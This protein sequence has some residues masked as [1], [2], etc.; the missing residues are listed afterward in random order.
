MMQ[1][2]QIDDIAEKLA[3]LS[4][5]GA[6][7]V[8][9]FDG[10]IDTIVRVVSGGPD[11]A[12][13]HFATKRAFGEKLVALGRANASFELTEVATKI[14]GNAPNTAQACGRLGLQ[15]EC[16][17]MLGHPEIHDLFAGMHA[18]CRL[19][20]FAPPTQTTALEFDDGKVLL[21]GSRIL[22]T[23]DW[24]AV[25][26]G[27]GLERLRALYADAD[28]VG[29]T[30]WGEIEHATAIWEGAEAGV[31]AAIAPRRRIVFFDLA[32][33]RRR[34]A[35][36]ARLFALIE[37]LTAGNETVLS[38]NRNEAQAVAR[39]LAVVTDGS[40][41]QLGAAIHRAI[42]VD[43]LIL[44]DPFEALA[45][46]AAGQDRTPTFHLAAPRVSTGGGDNF[47]AGYCFAR[48]AGLDTR[49][50]LLVAS[51]VAR[52]YVGNGESPDCAQLVDFLRAQAAG[53]T[54][55]REVAQ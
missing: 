49:A 23:V 36:F 39:H 2:D 10:F 55:A 11:E 34:Q 41:E 46:T 16:I 7:A 3:A 21:A 25:R 5:G 40:L 47:N 8:I 31:L 4:R 22:R 42:R 17:G 27:I 45:W 52:L 48:R 20:S 18:N 19:H 13:Q 26:D 51:A 54:P 12:Q 24:P 1:P 28:I 30:N 38:L 33:P 44:R 37:R 35:E 29:F 32:D 53:A 6:V 14:G 43:T 9:G 15:V 50:A